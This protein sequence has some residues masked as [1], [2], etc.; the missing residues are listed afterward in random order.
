MKYFFIIIQKDLNIALL[1]DCGL[2]G[3]W[4]ADRSPF[5][6][7]IYI[8]FKNVTSVFNVDLTSVYVLIYFQ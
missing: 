8:I 6:L 2:S 5:F 7:L 1:A 3:L 4:L